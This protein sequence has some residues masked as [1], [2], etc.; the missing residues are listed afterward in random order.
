MQMT[1][2]CCHTIEYKLSFNNSALWTNQHGK[3]STDFQGLY[4]LN[5]SDNLYVASE[6][7]SATSLYSKL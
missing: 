2:S 4:S 3:L 5:N 1:S 7:L 6:Q